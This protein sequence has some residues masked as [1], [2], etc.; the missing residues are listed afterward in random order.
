MKNIFYCLCLISIS[1]SCN[2]VEDYNELDS[3]KFLSNDYSL[4]Y[5]LEIDSTLNK[6]KL[7]VVSFNIKY[8]EELDKAIIEME[9]TDKI[10]KADIYLLQE[11]DETSVKTIAE[12]LSLN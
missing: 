3:P 6:P 12:N 7:K 10:S 2:K 4:D 1:F 8:G 9:S 5:D 11:M